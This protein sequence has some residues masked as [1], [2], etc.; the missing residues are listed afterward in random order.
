MVAGNAEMWPA[1]S[2]VG[3]MARCAAAVSRGVTGGEGKWG[4]ESES[5]GLVH[6]FDGLG[7]FGF[8]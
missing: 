5:Q 6:Y 1:T 4:G 3:E 7:F 8:Q 2:R